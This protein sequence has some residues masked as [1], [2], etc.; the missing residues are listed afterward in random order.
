[1]AV[2]NWFTIVTVTALAPYCFDILLLIVPLFTL[3]A[4]PYL[5]RPQLA[6]FSCATI[7]VALAMALLG[8]LGHDVGLQESTPAWILHGLVI[9]FV[10]VEAGLL[11]FLAWHNHLVMSAQTQHLRQAQGRLVAA[12]ASERQGIERS[13]RDR[14]QRRLDTARERLGGIQRLV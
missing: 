13:L 10:P 5:D 3:F 14:T 1:A 11:A 6:V 2:T 7:V 12:I 9:L 8:R 4:M